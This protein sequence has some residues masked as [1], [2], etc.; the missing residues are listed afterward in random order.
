VIGQAVSHYRM[1]RVGGGGMGVV[2]EAEDTRLG[3][4]VALKFLTE[5]R[6]LERAARALRARGTRRLGKW[7][8]RAATPED[9]TCAATSAMAIVRLAASCGSVA[10]QRGPHSRE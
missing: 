4:R 3:R 7:P 2:Y 6:E 9:D 5:E 1:L 10:A 8:G